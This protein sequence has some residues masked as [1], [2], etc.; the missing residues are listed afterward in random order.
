MS[1]LLVSAGIRALHESKGSRGCV[2]CWLAVPDWYNP[3]SNASGLRSDYD[4][5]HLLHIVRHPLTAIASLSRFVHGPWWHWQQV[6][7]GLV[8]ERESLDFY[9]R[10]WR[11]WNELIDAQQ[12]FARI[13]IEHP[14]ESWSLIAATLGA[15]T[16]M[17]RSEIDPTWVTKKKPTVEWGDLSAAVARETKEMA[18]YL[19]YKE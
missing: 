18:D 19:G 12:P 15:A 9:A 11:K 16:E 5:P 6:H 4:N 14:E 10:F 3:H 13:R 7:T 2:S 17:P 1:R 8:Y